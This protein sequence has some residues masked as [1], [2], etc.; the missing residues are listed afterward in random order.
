M[1]KLRKLIEKY[2]I[3]LTERVS[4]QR[5]LQ[6]VRDGVVQT[7]PLI[8]IGSFFLLLAQPPGEYL[9][10]LVAP[11]VSPL[12]IPYKLTFGLIS[13]YV[14]AASA[15][16]LAKSYKM[17][18]LS[19][20]L[21]STVTFFIAASPRMVMTNN[22]ISSISLPRSAELGW[23]L[24]LNN[25]GPEGLFLAIIVSLLSVELLRYLQERKLM[26][27]MPE[28]VPD[29]VAKAFESMIPS[30][31][32]ILAFWGLRDLLGL[33]MPHV[34]TKVF[35]P[36][37][38]LGDSII[39]VQVLTVFNSL[40][41][42]AGV[43]PVAF[44][45]PFTRP[46]WLA[47]LGEN[48]VAVET[49]AVLLPH[50]A[51]DQFYYWFVWIG[52]AG[53]TFGMLPH[54]LLAKSK[55]LRQLGKVC[56][57]PGLFNINE[58]LIFGIPI[59]ANP[60]MIIPFTLAPFIS[61]MVAYGAFYFNLVQRPYLNTPWTLPVPLGALLSTGGDWRAFMLS[62]VVIIICAVVY[63]PFMKVYDKQMLEREKAGE[64][65]S[66]PTEEKGGEETCEPGNA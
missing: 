13:I 52:G 66:Q 8:L 29:V 26:F 42:F 22:Q 19:T 58:P 49:G 11:Y 2:L 31:V 36:I 46:I 59:V 12:L 39:T 47:M 54:M 5:H 14:A 21:I 1:E 40:S 25:F 50:I 6:A 64:T 32:I 10:K 16:A 17:E 57:V 30:F 44:I 3:P 38:Q 60:L 37:K 33:D 28:G 18:G 35:S 53:A 41:W 7:L 34:V 51:V 48:Q 24:P 65:E 63:Y 4:K 45:G 9:Q 55:F 20:A 62:I 27:K 56:V 61:G 15:Y 23:Y 43:H